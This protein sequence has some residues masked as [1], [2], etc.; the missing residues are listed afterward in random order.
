MKII[1]GLHNVPNS[2]ACALSIGNFDGVHLGHQRIINA[3]VTCAKAHK[4]PA[5]VMSFQPT[6]QAFFNNPQAALTNLREKYQLL[7]ALGVDF[8]LI[9]PFNKAFSQQSAKAFVSDVLVAKLCVKY[10]LIGDDFRFGKDRTG[11]VNYLTQLGHQ[12]GFK[13][14]AIAA[15]NQ[16]NNRI[17]SSFIRQL[18]KAG[19]FVQAELFLAQPFTL[20]G[21]VGQGDKR[22][23]ELG[24]P[25]VNINL[26]RQ[27]SPIMGVFAVYLVVADKT[28]HAVANIGYRPTVKGNKLLLEVHI[29][30]F[31]QQIYGQWVRVIFKYKIRDEMTFTS[32]DEL[33]TQIKKDCQQA[34]QYLAKQLTTTL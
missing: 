6:P 17:S 4:L 34:Q 25:T 14:E 7:K 9:V 27:I 15:V 31:Q 8:L 12:Y 21:R 23:R 5:I 30:D 26:K 11:D 1:R 28:H 29:F 10:C 24:F 13:T 18:L 3:L 16:L 20:S 33:S 19:D 22:G 2:K 32:L